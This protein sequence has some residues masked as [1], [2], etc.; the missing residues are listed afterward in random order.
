L[1]ILREATRPARLA[2]R[3]GALRTPPAIGDHGMA[4]VEPDHLSNTGRRQNCRIIAT[5]EPVPNGTGLMSGVGLHAVRERGRLVTEPVAEQ[6]H[7]Q[8]TTTSQRGR[9]CHSHEVA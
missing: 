5:R 7:Q 2:E 3:Q 9:A 1:P 4:A 8:H 6:V